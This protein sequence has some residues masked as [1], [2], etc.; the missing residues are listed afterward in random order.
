MIGFGVMFFLSILMSGAQSGPTAGASSG[1]V[2]VRG[3]ELGAADLPNGGHVSLAE[4]ELGLEIP[5]S[6][7][8]GAL[9]RLSIR[10]GLVDLDTPGAVGR[11]AEMELDPLLTTSVGYFLAVPGEDGWSRF[12]RGGIMFSG[13]S[14]AKAEDSLIYNG[15]GGAEYAWSKDLSFQMGLLGTS[16]LEADPLVLPMVGFRWRPAPGWMVATEGPGLKING[17]LRRD[18]QFTLNAGWMT[19][20]WRLDADAPTPEGVLATD[21]I[22]LETGLLWK[23]GPAWQFGAGVG[24]EPSRTYRLLDDKGHDSGILTAEGA[25]LASLSATYRF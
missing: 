20:A 13:E 15:M 6:P 24:W 23:Y 4:S 21:A 25:P 9:G 22:R 19:R 17:P 16:R 2:S 12:V 3:V 8:T 11:V 18:L 10:T 5:L 7:T 1:S 14:G